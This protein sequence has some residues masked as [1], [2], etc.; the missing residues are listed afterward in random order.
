MSETKFLTK[1]PF[2]QGAYNETDSKAKTVVI[3]IMK[4][5]GYVVHG[6]P[7]QENYK[8]YDLNFYNKTTHKFLAVE[9]EVRRDFELIR[10]RWD[11]VHIPVRKSNT[12]MDCYFVWNENVD[13]A[14]LIDRSTFMKY[15]KN[16]VDIDCDTEV[17]DGD[18]IA[19]KEKFIDVPKSE[20][21]F[22]YLT[23]DYKLND[24]VVNPLIYGFLN[25]Q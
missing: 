23:G 19:Y 24:R 20:C 11:T 18:R 25:Y 13:Q 7:D 8:K 10:D 2:N 16:L 4:R 3:E 12:Q 21:K 1:R 5:L 6:N 15:V 17:L 9:N 14:I 22:Y